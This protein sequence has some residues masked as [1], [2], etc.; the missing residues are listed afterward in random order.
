M[1]CFARIDFNVSWI[2]FHKQTTYSGWSIVQ[3]IIPPLQELIFT[4]SVTIL[5]VQ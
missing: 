2:D 5:I 1:E 4:E 3:E